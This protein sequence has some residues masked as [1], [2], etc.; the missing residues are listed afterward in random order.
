MNQRNNRDCTVKVFFIL[1][2]ITVKDKSVLN[3]NNNTLW[4]ILKRET[5]IIYV[6]AQ[7]FWEW[8]KECW[9]FEDVI[10]REYYIKLKDSSRQYK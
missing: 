2:N 10:M 5:R 8:M 3:S 4:L 9:N 7:Y 6:I 1:I